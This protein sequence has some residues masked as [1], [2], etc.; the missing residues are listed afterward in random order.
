VN[1]LANNPAFWLALI[2][3]LATLYLL[4]I[5]I[6]A[7]RKAEPMSVIIILTVFPLLWPAALIGAFMLPRK[8]YQPVPQRC[9][10]GG[11]PHIGGADVTT[12]GA[13]GL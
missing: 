7:V 3:G 10:P 11:L 5:V 1:A 4:P 6:G 8:R 2:I 13:R 12:S 9:A